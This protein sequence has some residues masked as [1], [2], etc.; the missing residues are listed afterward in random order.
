M[1]AT[2]TDNHIQLTDEEGTEVP[3]SHADRGDK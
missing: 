1:S 3:P 2:Q